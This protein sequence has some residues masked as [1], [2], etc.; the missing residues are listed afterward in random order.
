MKTVTDLQTTILMDQ[1]GALSALHRFHSIESSSIVADY[2]LEAGVNALYSIGVRDEEYDRLRLLYAV[3]VRHFL[4]DVAHGATTSVATMFRAA[5]ELP[6]TQVAVGNFA[7]RRSFDQFIKHTK[8]LPDAIKIGIG[9]G[10]GCTTRETTGVGI[11]YITNILDFKDCG[12]SLIID[13][14]CRTPGDVCKALAA[15]AA[16]CMIGKMFAQTVEAPNDGQYF[17]NGAQRNNV[18][19]T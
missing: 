4:I 8:A 12:S 13:G 5:K 3:G 10:A 9:G 11:P 16:V 17:G 19:E 2:L 14:G 6:N 7:T 15:G 18:N 1:Y